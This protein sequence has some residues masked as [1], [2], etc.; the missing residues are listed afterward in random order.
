MEKLQFVCRT[1]QRDPAA[2]LVAVRQYSNLVDTRFAKRNM[3]EGERR[4][5]HEKSWST[6]K[7]EPG[8]RTPSYHTETLVVNPLSH[9]DRQLELAESVSQLGID[10]KL[11]CSEWKGRSRRQGDQRETLGHSGIL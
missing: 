5:D 3:T 10:P 4:V 6:R 8:N 2:G 7:L 1:S 9:F 11:L